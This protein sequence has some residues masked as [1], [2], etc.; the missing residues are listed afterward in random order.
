[1][2]VAAVDG[3]RHLEEVFMSLVGEGQ[4]A[5]VADADAADAGKVRR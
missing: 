5:Q 3:R 2:P 1:M 4:P